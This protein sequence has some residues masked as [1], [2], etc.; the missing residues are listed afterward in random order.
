MKEHEIEDDNEGDL[1]DALEEVVVKADE[2]NFF[3]WNK[4]GMIQKKINMNEGF[5]S[6]ARFRVSYAH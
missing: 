5:P 3:L 2:V 4:L 1:E 6:L